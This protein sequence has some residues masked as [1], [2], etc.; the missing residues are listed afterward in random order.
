[1]SRLIDADKFC[2]FVDKHCKDNI[3]VLWKELIRRQPT[4]YDVDEVTKQ[5]KEYFK[6]CIDK[7]PS[8]IVD[9]EE[10]WTGIDSID[11]ILKHNEAITKILKGGLNEEEQKQ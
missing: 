7:L 4:A 3:A 10:V 11:E 1:M 9:G 5:T 6:R 8:K 2:E